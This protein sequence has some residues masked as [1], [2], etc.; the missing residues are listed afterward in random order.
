MRQIVIESIRLLIIGMAPDEW[1]RNGVM[2]VCSNN[3]MSH[4]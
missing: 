2:V 1:K 4:V 3:H